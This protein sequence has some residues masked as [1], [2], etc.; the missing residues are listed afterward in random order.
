MLYRES[1]KYRKIQ[2]KVMHNFIEIDQTSTNDEIY[3]LALSGLV[4]LDKCKS[5]NNNKY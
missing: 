4:P 5:I 2:N 3:L 1:K